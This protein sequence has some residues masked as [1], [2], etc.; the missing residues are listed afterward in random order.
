VNKD[1]AAF[2]TFDET[3]SLCV[4]EPFHFSNS[5]VLLFSPI[6][7]P[8]ETPR[9]HPSDSIVNGF[10]NEVKTMTEDWRIRLLNLDATHLIAFKAL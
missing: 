2:L 9:A 3:K 6:F 8:G 4:I 10:L 1:V 5:H 7:K